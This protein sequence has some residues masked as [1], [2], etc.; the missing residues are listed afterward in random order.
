MTSVAPINV[1]PGVTVDMNGLTPESAAGDLPTDNQSSEGNQLSTPTNPAKRNSAPSA[2]QAA[3][4]QPQKKTKK[5]ED[6]GDTVVWLDVL[7]EGVT[8]GHIGFDKIRCLP[9][10]VKANPMTGKAAPIWIVF[11]SLQKPIRE[12]TTPPKRT[13]AVKIGAT[14]TKIY[15]HICLE[16]LKEVK[17]LGTS[18][19][20]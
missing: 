4:R 16:C 2:D 5:K 17:A 20:E 9:I 13:L 10:S 14:M 18:A 7:L 8:C 1:A 6:D 11:R 3:D 12:K 19:H 15:Q